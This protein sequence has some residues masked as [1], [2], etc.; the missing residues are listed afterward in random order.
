MMVDD[1]E[2]VERLAR[3]EE[4]LGSLRAELTQVLAEMRARGDDQEQRIR[5]LEKSVAR[6]SERLGLLAS[7]LAIWQVITSAVAAWIGATR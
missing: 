5:Q 4:N 1:V 3:I 7:G 6:H 2:L